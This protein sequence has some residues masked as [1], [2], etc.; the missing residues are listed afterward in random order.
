MAFHIQP[1]NAARTETTELPFTEGLALTLERPEPHAAIAPA[2]HV[3][4]QGQSEGMV[5][6]LS[7][8]LSQLDG[9]VT[10]YRRRLKEVHAENTANKAKIAMLESRYRGA[11]GIPPEVQRQIEGLRALTA[12]QSEEILRLRETIDRRE[13]EKSALQGRVQQ[14]Q[15]LLSTGRREPDGRV[16]FPHAT[17]E[18]LA[19]L[20]DGVAATVGVQG[21]VRLPE[22]RVQVPEVPGWML[23]EGGSHE[24]RSLRLA[25]LGTPRVAPRELN[26]REALVHLERDHQDLRQELDLLPEAGTLLGMLGSVNG[27]L[28]AIRSKIVIHHRTWTQ[29]D[30]D[31]CMAQLERA[32]QVHTEVRRALRALQRRPVE[33]VVRPSHP[34]ATLSLEQR[35]TRL[36]EREEMRTFRESIGLPQEE[37]HSER[38]LLRRRRRDLRHSLDPTVDHLRRASE[39]LTRASDALSHVEEEPPRPRLHFPAVSADVWRAAPA[40]AL[41]FESLHRTLEEK[42]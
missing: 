34:S 19:G 23:G 24:Q 22:V 2:L 29:T 42:L 20:V 7:T 3:L 28:G 41:A 26:P 21:R 27:M 10:T 15:G 38:E 37:L 18:R 16:S 6:T 5:E 25:D 11:A 39:H 36:E 32:R 35:V 31:L 13:H 9:M 17:A 14:L 4:L 1:G 33:T 8:Q 40:M 12:E 30:Q